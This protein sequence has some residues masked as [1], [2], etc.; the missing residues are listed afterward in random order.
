VHGGCFTKNAWTPV[1][2]LQATEIVNDVRRDIDNLRAAMSKKGKR[3]NKGDNP[4]I[5]F[6]QQRYVV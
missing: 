6:A 5:S 2:T 4:D 3:P 1:V